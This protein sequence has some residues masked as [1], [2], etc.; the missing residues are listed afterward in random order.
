MSIFHQGLSA[1]L[2][3]ERWGLGR[4][5]IDA[6]SLESH[7][8]AASAADSGR[9]AGEITPISVGEGSEARLISDDECIRRDTSLE[10][11]AGLKP[12]FKPDG[13]VTAGNSSQIADGA[14]AVLLMTR[15][16]A[17]EH[18]LRPRARLRTTVSV[19]SDP[20]LMLTGPIPATRKA[21]ARTALRMDDIDV[22]EINEAFATVV[23]AWQRELRPKPERVNP[24]GGAV[25]LGHPLGA[26]GAR[27]FTTLLHE[28]ERT[29]G[30]LGLITMCIGFGMATATIIEREG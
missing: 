14:A 11:L 7:R 8:R 22:T 1:D 21:L 19:G 10:R 17:K 27:L 25:A 26:S 3:A 29:E 2:I 4:E 15:A 16:T 6:F 9:F 18:G 5:E 13:V 12:S 20:D 23:L 24:N 30:R 28:L